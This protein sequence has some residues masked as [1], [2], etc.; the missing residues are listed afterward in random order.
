MFIVSS[1]FFM[2]ARMMPSGAIPPKYINDTCSNPVIF[3]IY[4]KLC[5][6]IKNIVM[7][8]LDSTRNT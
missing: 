8:D 7:I 4:R 2:M 6:D 5:I 3:S 1:V